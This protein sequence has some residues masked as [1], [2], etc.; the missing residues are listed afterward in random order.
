MEEKKL[1]EES[2]SLRYS[3]AALVLFWTNLDTVIRLM[4]RG[5][6]S[7][8]SIAGIVRRISVPSIGALFQVQPAV[9]PV[10]SKILLVPR[11]YEAIATFYLKSDG[12]DHKKD[13]YGPFIKN[14]VI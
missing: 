5:K 1:R 9:I 3:S 10:G 2:V 11:S 7:S 6:L 4:S 12:I 13:P 14:V 8:L